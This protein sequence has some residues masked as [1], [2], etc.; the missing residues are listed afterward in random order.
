[1]GSF[2]KAA[3]ATKLT[4]AALATAEAVAANDFAPGPKREQSL[5]DISDDQIRALEELSRNV[6][7]RVDPPR[8][9]APEVS[10]PAQPMSAEIGRV[11]VL[12]L[13]TGRSRPPRLRRRLINVPQETISLRVPSSVLDDFDVWCDELGLSKKMGFMEMVR[14]IVHRSRDQVDPD[15]AALAAKPVGDDLDDLVGQ[16]PRRLA[17]RTATEHLEQATFFVPCR[18]VEAFEA[19]CEQRGLTKKDGFIEMVRRVRHNRSRDRD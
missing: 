16:L 11:G 14:R 18:I 9:P 19:W 12:P 13:E 6:G 2:G 1:M 15:D 5:E 8:N 3:A 4:T 7:Y 10:P 17:R